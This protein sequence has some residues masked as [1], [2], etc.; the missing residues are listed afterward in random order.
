MDSGT[1]PHCGGP[2]DLFA[3]ACQ[4]CGSALLPATPPVREDTA[5][6]R[7]DV[8]PEEFEPPATSRFPYFRVAA[9][10]VVL[11]LI[12]GVV[13]D[14]A[15]QPPSPISLPEG[16]GPNTVNVTSVLVWAPPTACGLNGITPGAFS[17]PAYTIHLLGWFPPI[18][19]PVPCYVSS[20]S[21]NS[22]GFSISSNLPVD[23]TSSN[24]GEALLLTIETPA[25]FEGIQYLGFH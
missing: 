7:L 9:V 21:T 3:E 12:L 24:E 15:Q 2:N 1:C 25:S 5:D 20:V 6:S 18:L 17:V 13:I 14:S 19:G 10:V 8:V 11:I 4:W 23:V 22:S 16:S